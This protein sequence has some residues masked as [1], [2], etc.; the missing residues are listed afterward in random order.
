VPHDEFLIASFFSLS[1]FFCCSSNPLQTTV[2][3][4]VSNRYAEDGENFQFAGR[5]QAMHKPVLFILA[6]VT[7]AASSFA[8][9]DTLGAE[10]AAGSVLTV[11]TQAPLTLDPSTAYDANSLGLLQN[12]YVRLTQFGWKPGPA[13]TLQIDPQHVLPYLARSI[14]ISS[15]GKRYTFKLRPA[16][17]N[18]GSPINAAA[19]KFSL[20]RELTMGNTGAYVITNG[21]SHL[22]ASI[23]TPTPD[24]V[25]L[26]LT[27]PNTDMLRDLAESW[28]SIVE[29]KVVNQNGGVKAG[30][31]NQWMS[32]HIAGGGGPFLLQSYSPATSANL[33]RNPTFFGRPAKSSTI[34]MNFL[35]SDVTLAL[36]ARS[37]A[38]DVTLGLSKQA[39]VGLKGAKGLRI[40]ADQTDGVQRLTMVDT[41]PPFNN[42]L[43]REALTYALPYQ[44]IL[45][46]VNQGFGTLLYGP[47]APAIPG[48]NH[49]LEKPRRWDIGKAKQLLQQ[50]GVTLPVTV[51]MAVQDDDATGLQI[52]T[53]V[54]SLWQ[55][56]GINIQIVKLA[57]AAFVAA[58]YKFQ[59][60]L[61]WQGA[62]PGVYSALYQYG[63]DIA[64]GNAFNAS[65][66]CIPAAD[67]LWKQAQRT[68]DPKKVEALVNKII[69]LYNNYAPVIPVYA[70]EAVTVLGSRVHSYAWSFEMDLRGW[71]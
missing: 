39:V 10:A 34:K 60:P 26:N 54:Q 45:A 52:A 12:F 70:D 5:S 8:V 67:A 42:Q 23:Q 30:G 37:G 31:I 49:Q 63:Y 65:H 15:D 4:A 3:Q 47:F 38:A 24:T 27:T 57:P 53:I 13:G 64:C 50:S 33:V 62:A 44:D 56:L 59:Y 71:G 36:Q 6:A 48:F 14:T 18:D 35:T 9:S 21:I 25:V 2:V 11:N 22:Y 58:V 61:E 46:K 19:V 43:V 32:S 66:A 29:P 20:E 40:I 69:R 41:L 28:G 55:S 16:K 51:Q 17:F 68:A 7:V 1:G